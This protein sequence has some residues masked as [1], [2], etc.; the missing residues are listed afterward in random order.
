MLLT[1]LSSLW[2]RHTL[3]DEPVYTETTTTNRLGWS[4]TVNVSPKALTVLGYLLVFFMV[5]GGRYGL[6]DFMLSIY[7]SFPEY[8][9][10]DEP[11]V[12]LKKKGETKW[13]CRTHYLGYAGCYLVSKSWSPG[14]LVLYFLVHAALVHPTLLTDATTAWMACFQPPV[15]EQGEKTD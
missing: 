14:W 7:T 10:T 5:V 4:I 2:M 12:V 9:S 8:P 1:L 15:A 6:A 3:E 11:L 13:T